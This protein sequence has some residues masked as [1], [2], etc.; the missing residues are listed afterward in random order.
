MVINDTARYFWT[1]L[2]KKKNQRELLLLYFSL[3]YQTL[4]KLSIV[5]L[6]I[7]FLK[8]PALHLL[9]VSSKAVTGSSVV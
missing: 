4:G 6:P 5:K 7:C 8:S 1:R 9:Q 3:T 2:K